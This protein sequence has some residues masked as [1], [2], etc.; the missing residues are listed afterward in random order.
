MEYPFYKLPFEE[1]TSIDE[2]VDY[3]HNQ[4]TA[5]QIALNQLLEK[6]GIP[7]MPVIK[8]VQQIPFAADL[9]PNQGIAISEDAPFDGYIKEVTIHWPD[10]AD[11]LVD[12]RIEHRG[13][14]F[15]PNPA[16]GQKYL[17]LN[18]ATPTYA[19]N[20]PMESTRPIT[21]EMRNTDSGNS[22][23]ISV[24]VMVESK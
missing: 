15:C 20:E 23:A 8:S 7:T 4:M 18:D 24:S 1:L 21:V 10:G 11:S 16:Y 17:A 6:E 5:S 12:V 19:F 3:I 2:R 14:Q 22:H 9:E 13:K